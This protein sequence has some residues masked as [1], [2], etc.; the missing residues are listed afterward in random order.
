MKK[1]VYH[2]EL[3]RDYPLGLIVKFTGKPQKSK[4]GDS[5]YIYFKVDGDQ[6]DHYYNIENGDIASML[7]GAPVDQWVKL[8]AAGSRDAAT[9]GLEDQDGNPIF[10]NEPEKHPETQG[11][12]PNEWPDDTVEEEDLY[13]TL[14]VLF[15]KWVTVVEEAFPD[16]SDEAKLEG[17]QKMTCTEWI[18]K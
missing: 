8:Y 3:T 7:Q 5:W 11:P 16:A 17:V 15:H 10:P 4:D 1:G 6:E 12:P 14:I 13:D 2:S 18:S 9:I